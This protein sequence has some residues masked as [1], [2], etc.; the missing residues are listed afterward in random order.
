MS[1][2]RGCAY[3]HSRIISCSDCWKLPQNHLHIYPK[4][5]AGPAPQPPALGL[6]LGQFLGHFPS[7]HVYYSAFSP[8][9]S[10]EYL[11]C[12]NM[13]T[14]MVNASKTSIHISQRRRLWLLETRDKVVEWFHKPW[15]W[16]ERNCIIFRV[17]KWSSQ[18]NCLEVISS[19][20]WLT[21]LIDKLESI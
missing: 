1:I 9:W 12:K 4:F 10:S 8:Y 7:C 15:G 19:E 18:E 20:T 14:L 5:S 16:E 17:E 3:L 13:L 2:S 6:H 21:Q 11:C